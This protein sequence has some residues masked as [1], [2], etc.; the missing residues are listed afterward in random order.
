MDRLHFFTPV[1]IARGQ[2]YPLEEVDSVSE[3][4]VFLRKWPTGRRGPV[5]QCAVNCCSAAMAGKM[6]AEEARK[7]F[8]GFARITRILDDEMALPLGG[9]S[10]DNVYA[11]RR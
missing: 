9:V 4:M 6:S 5:Y 1:R 8:V 3:A 11:L 7:A 2:G 10:T